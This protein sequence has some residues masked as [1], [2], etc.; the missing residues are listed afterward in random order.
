LF[1]VYT[2]G[3]S[4]NARAAP[5]E[6][7]WRRATAHGSWGSVEDEDDEDDCTDTLFVETLV[8]LLETSI[9]VVVLPSV[10]VLCTLPLSGTGMLLPFIVISL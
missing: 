9:V 5:T 7:T 8:P 6:P 4:P 3:L 10:T 2:L 1:I